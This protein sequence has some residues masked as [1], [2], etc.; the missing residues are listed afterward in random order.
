M[1]AA[2]DARRTGAL[3]ANAFKWKTHGFLPTFASPVM[4]AERLY[5][6]DNGAIL[7]AFD[8]KDG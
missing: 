7:G 1:V 8:L 2:V 6:V 4:D 3:D 5:T